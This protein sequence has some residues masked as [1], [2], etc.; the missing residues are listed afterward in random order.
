MEG[1]VRLAVSVH[2]FEI[3]DDLVAIL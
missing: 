2:D 1:F 3:E